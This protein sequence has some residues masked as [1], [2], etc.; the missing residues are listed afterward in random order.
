[1]LDFREDARIFRRD[2]GD[3]GEPRHCKEV[4]IP[5]ELEDQALV[6]IEI[7]NAAGQLVRTLDLGQQPRGRYVRNGQAAYWDGR[8][9]FG[10]R[11]S[12]GIYF[13]VLRAGDFLATRNM[14][15]LK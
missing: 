7:Y 6:S 2:I 4:W 12:S 3:L 13:Y 9:A 5:Y 1:M 14:V 10:E 8:S 11:V 15:L